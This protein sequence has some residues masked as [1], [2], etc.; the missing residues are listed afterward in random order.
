[1]LMQLRL[2]FGY[3]QTLMPPFRLDVEKLPSS[4]EALTIYT[5]SGKLSIETVNE[6]LPRLRAE[7]AQRVILD[8]NGVSFLDSAGV[9]ALVSIFVSRR[10]QGKEFGLASLQAQAQAVVTVAGLQNLL[11]IY[12]S[13]ED[14]SAKKA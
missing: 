14:A 5:A 10:S 3:I 1:M 2:A 8:L 7:S 11:P 6:F 9:G 13:V 4:T 12:K